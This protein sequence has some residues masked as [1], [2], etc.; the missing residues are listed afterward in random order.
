MVYGR[1]F[2]IFFLNRRHFSKIISIFLQIFKFFIS[3][4]SNFGEKL[5]NDMSP[6]GLFPT[7][8]NLPVIILR[9]EMTPDCSE[10]TPL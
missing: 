3:D 6:R 4:V 10:K 8:R 7:L 2:F 1:Y 5:K 9:T